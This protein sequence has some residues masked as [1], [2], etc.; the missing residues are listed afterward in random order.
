MIR[1]LLVDD[2]E[3]ALNLLEI[4]L[5]RIGDVE[6]V[7][8]YVNPVQAVEALRASPV[9]AVFLDNEM[10]GMSGME[11]ARKMR[12][13][14]P[15]V[16]IVFTTAHAEYAVEAF[17]IESTDYLLKPLAL[18][19]LEHAV[20]RI[21]QA[22]SRLSDRSDVVIRCLGGFAIALPH[23]AN[24]T[25]PWRTNKEKELCAFLIHHGEKQVDTALIIESIWPGYDLRKAKTYLYTCLSYLRK[26]FQDHDL[27][28]R[29]EKSEN[30]FALRL[31]GAATD[32]HVFEKTLGDVML[33][34]KPDKPMFDKLDGLYRGEYMEGCDYSWAVYKQAALNAK[35]LRALR[36]LYRHFRRLGDTASA[37]DCLRRVLTLAPDSEADGR[38]LIRLLMDAGD[39]SEA[40]RVYRQLEQVICEQLGIELEE[41]TIRLYRQIRRSG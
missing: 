19:R 23:D 35:Y 14:R 41:E 26:S 21:R 25:L 13:I 32:V 11:T 31:N 12:E 36:S 29:V 10:P 15:R 8:R 40:L 38:E 18:N 4:L 2:E 24:R 30:G 20:S 16:P 9:D 1:V 22:V 6:V 17:E 33:A 7:G 28:M 27:P 34:E 39:R 5:N 3:D 37:E